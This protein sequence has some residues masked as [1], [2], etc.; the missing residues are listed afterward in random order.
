MI[1][2]MKKIVIIAALFLCHYVSPATQKTSCVSDPAPG[3][4]HQAADLLDEVRVRELINDYQFP[5]DQ[6][7]DRGRLPIHYAVDTDMEN[8]NAMDPYERLVR[9][10]AIINLLRSTLTRPTARNF[11]VMHL[12][13]RS[14]NVGLARVFHQY[15][16][17]FIMARDD[18]GNT[19]LSY[20]AYFNRIPLMYYFIDIL[21]MPVNSTDDDGKTPLDYAIRSGARQAIIFLIRHNA[22]IHIANREGATPL[23]FAE[24]YDDENPVFNPADSLKSLIMR[25]YIARHNDTFFPAVSTI[26]GLGLHRMQTACSMLLFCMMSHLTQSRSKL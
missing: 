1:K 7:D 24:I 19:P 10:V 26:M 14:G 8:S 17:Q 16:N 13:A 2:F 11:N 6:Y 20:A 22:S 3:A 25:E 15:N 21:H 12:V 23:D 18:A 9:Q 5:I 4:L